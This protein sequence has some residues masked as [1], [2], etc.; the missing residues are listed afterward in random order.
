[1]SL[2]PALRM[3]RGRSLRPAWS[4]YIESFRQDTVSRKKKRWEG[5]LILQFW[6]IPKREGIN[7]INN[8]F[9]VSS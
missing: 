1:M 5:G 2:I 9:P 4:R 7:K 3:Q 8:D 6:F